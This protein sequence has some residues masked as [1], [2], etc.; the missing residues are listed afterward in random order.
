[1]WL[2]LTSFQVVNGDVYVIMKWF[3]LKGDIAD[4]VTSG[5]LVPSSFKFNIMPYM[6]LYINTT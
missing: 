5:I 2:I 4:L 3:S 6:L 1:M